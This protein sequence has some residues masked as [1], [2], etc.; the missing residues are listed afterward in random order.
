MARGQ[1]GE[2]SRLDMERPILIGI[3]AVTPKP[4]GF[5]ADADVALVK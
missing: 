5:M 3:A 1:Q 2:L 4:D